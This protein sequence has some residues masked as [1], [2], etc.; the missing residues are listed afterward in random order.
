M[1]NRNIAAL[2]LAIVQR[3]LQRAEHEGSPHRTA[4][5]P[6]DNVTGEDIDGEGNVDETPLCRNVREIGYPQLIRP[7]LLAVDP[8]EREWSL[9]VGHHR[10]YHFT[11]QCSHVAANSTLCQLRRLAGLPVKSAR[12]RR[13]TRR[14]A[15]LA[16]NATRDCAAA[17][18]S[19]SS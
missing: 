8:V 2:D 6:A 9:C 15:G 19:T 12:C 13:S 11:A 14:N 1:V 3:L 10:T 16:R 18:R 5:P 7:L 17:Q 4:H